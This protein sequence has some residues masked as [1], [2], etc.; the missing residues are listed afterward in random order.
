[1]PGILAIFPHPD[2]ESFSCGGTLAHYAAKGVPI[3]LICATKG[4]AGKRRGQPPFV[5]KSELPVV[6]EQELLKAAA[7]LGVKDVRFLH[8]PDKKVEKYEPEPLTGKIVQ[9]IRTVQ[10]DVLITFGPY[11]AFNYHTDHRALGRCVT[12]AFHLS[13]DPQYVLPESK[14]MLPFSVPKLYF[15]VLSKEYNDSSLVN[16]KKE[17]MTK[18]D[19][20][21]TWLQKIQALKS[22]LTQFQQE[23]WVWNDE[24]ARDKLPSWEGFIQ[25]HQPYVADETDFFS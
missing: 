6:R 16:A 8:L 19:I 1:M 23:E 4:E 24:Q 2:D 11:G 20:S 3:T 17:Q 9:L 13:G 7:C 10:P 15:P 14:E 22:H 5:E 18:I 21:Q 25:Y 12:H